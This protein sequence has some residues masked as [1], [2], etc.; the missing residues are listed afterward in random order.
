[1]ARKLIMSR[2]MFKNISLIIF[3]YLLSVSS[4]FS[5]NVEIENRLRKHVL[6]FTSDSLYGRKAGS[7]G[8]RIASEY[9]YKA[10]SDYSVVMTTNKSG[11]DFAVMMD[12]DSVSSRNIVGIIEGYD[13][14]LKNE[15]VVIGASI[16]NVGTN[17]L[18]INGKEIMQIFPGA[19]SNA[20]GLAC[21]IEVAQRIASS[22]FLFRRSVVIAGFG[23]KELAMAGSWYFVNRA[24]PFVKNISMMVD[25]NM[26]GRLGPNNYFTYYTGIP[27]RD[28]NTAIDSTFRQVS[29]IKPQMGTGQSI[30]SDYL[31]FYEQNI[32]AVLFTTGMHRDYHTIKDTEDQLDY[33]SMERI[34]EYIYTFVREVAN[35]D[36]KIEVGVVTEISE[37]E[38]ETVY[39]VFDIDKAPEFFHG[40]EKTFLERWVY[41]YLKYPSSPLTMG[42]QGEVI[43]EFIVEKDG[44][45]SNVKVVRSIDD[46]L[47]AEAIKVVSASPKWKPGVLKGRKVRVKYSIP[48]EFRLK[49]R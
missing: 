28:I 31:A 49:K 33:E 46:D 25:M 34:C 8:E 7:E 6:F 15:Y 10:L 16:D 1:M 42:I 48:I 30:P 2:C 29:F 17:V 23:A 32:P 21:L 35:K 26:L 47:D 11:E 27:Y 9:L 14:K 24:F 3:F 41:S 13:T 19:D 45:V 20:S 12:G 4:L 40:D 38:E 5:Q 22:S 36:E 43:V 37:N 39:S 44:S 18:N